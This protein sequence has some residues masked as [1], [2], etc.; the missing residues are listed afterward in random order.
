MEL[1][2]GI[3]KYIWNGEYKKELKHNRRCGARRKRC[4]KRGR[5]D[6]YAKKLQTKALRRMIMEEEDKMRRKDTFATNVLEIY[7]QRKRWGKKSLTKMIST[8]NI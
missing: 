5:I 7:R 1:G 6:E 3:G 8:N 4:G 2:E